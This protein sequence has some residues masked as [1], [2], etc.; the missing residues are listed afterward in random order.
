MIMRCALLTLASIP[1]AAQVS[2]VALSASSDSVTAFASSGAITLPTARVKLDINYP[3]GRQE[4]CELTV[5][6]DPQSG[7]YLW[8]HTELASGIP[9]GVHLG[10]IKTH[11]TAVF[12]DP[13]GLVYFLFGQ[14]M[15][16]KVWNARADSLDAAVSRSI[17]EIRGDLAS[18]EH[19]NWH[20][21][22]KFIP[23]FGL[24]RGF[25]AKLPPGFKRIPDGFSC[26]PLHSMCDDA[27]NT[28]VSVSRQ[29]ANWRLVLRNRWDE[30]VILDKD[31]NIL[32]MQQLTQPSQ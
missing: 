29:G 24:I 12:A 9:D 8:H 2:T 16:A 30:E 4:R 21:D 26:K 28:I 6:Y 3:H 20:S 17:D 19:R 22:Y 5:V 10:L 31:F 7:Y 13:A 14:M 27:S 1:L 18:Y 23:V 11:R 32:S 25:T 15:G